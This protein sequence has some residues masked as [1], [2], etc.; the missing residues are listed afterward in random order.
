MCAA[1]RDA[2][3]EL[4]TLVE[5]VGID[6]A[7]MQFYERTCQV[8]SDTRTD[9]AVIGAGWRLIEALEY[10][11]ELILWNLLAVVADGDIGI[12]VVMGDADADLS[13]RRRKF[14]GIREDV[15]NDLVEVLTVDPYG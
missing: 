15:D 2:D 9:V 12:L 10:L 14:K 4:T 13:A 6:G 8:E 3:D 1:Q 7:V 11:V 5:V